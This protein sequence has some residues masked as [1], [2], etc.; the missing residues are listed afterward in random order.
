MTNQELENIFQIE[1]ESK[2]ID[3]FTNSGLHNIASKHNCNFFELEE[4]ILKTK[5]F[6][7]FKHYAGI[8]IFQRFD[9]NLNDLFDAIDFYYQ[10]YNERKGNTIFEIV[11]NHKEL[12]LKDNSYSFSASSIKEKLKQLK[13]TK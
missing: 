7:T 6:K 10:K 1:I 2:K 9:L 13:A 8:T 5:G 4:Y 12:E 11:E 3:E